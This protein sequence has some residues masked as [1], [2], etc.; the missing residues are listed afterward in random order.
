MPHDLALRLV[1]TLP[2][3]LPYLFNCYQEQCDHESVIDG[4]GARL[5]RLAKHLD[6]EPEVILIGEAGGFQG[7]HFSGI[8]FTSERLLLEGAIPRVPAPPERLSRNRREPFSEPSA[9]IVWKTLQRLQIAERTI[10][11]NALQLH[12]FTVASI[13]S[14]RT[15]RQL[16]FNYGH[17]A[18][19]ILRAEF[20]LAKIVAVG[21]K[22]EKQ[23][24][25]L[26][27]QFAGAV[28]HPAYGGAAEFDKG[29]E[30][31]LNRRK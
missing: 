1:N 28:R 17:A 3:G 16:E 27:I 13:L 25:R 23:L 20:P 18:L 21:V 4:P 22:A 12:P 15:P 8:A 14:N 24:N 5:K 2:T 7:M 30:T 31:I 6:C 29:V 11:W 19:R 26:G 10:L 9:T